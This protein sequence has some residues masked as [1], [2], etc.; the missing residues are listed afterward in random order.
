MMLCTCAK[1]SLMGVCTL[2]P[3][4]P[5]KALYRI[6]TP[7]PFPV[8]Q[9]ADFQRREDVEE[10]RNTLVQ[11]DHL[12]PGYPRPNTCKTKAELRVLYKK[13][14]EVFITVARSGE[15]REHCVVLS[16]GCRPA[17]LHHGGYRMEAAGLLMT[18]NLMAVTAYLTTPPISF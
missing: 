15:L 13:Q 18:V 16:K 2:F 6:L 7:P 14:L 9:K 8:R 3:N 4:I 17:L 11:L 5:E 10:C 12:P 1:T